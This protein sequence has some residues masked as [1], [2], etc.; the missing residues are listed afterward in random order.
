MLPC[1]PQ[2][3]GASCKRGHENMCTWVRV[4]AAH[5]SREKGSGPRMLTQ[6]RCHFCR[7]CAIPCRVDLPTQTCASD[8]GRGLPRDVPEGRPGQGCRGAEDRARDRQRHGLP[9]QPR[10]RAWGALLRGVGGRAR[11]SICCGGAATRHSLRSPLLR[12]LV[13][14]RIAL[15]GVVGWVS[16]QTPA[17]LQSA[18]ARGRRT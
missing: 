11:A 17:V 18:D 13:L 8:A 9:A 16:M 4:R 12:S 5:C 7:S 2:P 15:P 10:H 6:T 1:K 14:L 3:A